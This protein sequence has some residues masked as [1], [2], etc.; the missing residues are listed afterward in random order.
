MTNPSLGFVH[1]HVPASTPSLPI[2]LLL[3]GTGGDENDLVPLGH[4]LLP[5][6]EIV[7]PRGKVLENGMPRFFRRL[8]EGVFDLEDLEFRAGELAEFVSSAAT[9]YGF[10]PQNLVA[11]G[12]SNGA[13]IA[14]A[15]LLL[16]PRTLAGA[17][18]FHAQIPLL[19][20]TKPDLQGKSIFLSGGRLDNLVPPGETERLGALLREY[21]ANLT[22]HWEQAGHNL[23]RG[24]IEAAH[25]WLSSI[26][27]DGSA[28][29]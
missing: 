9:A 26:W 8:A 13:N 2:L 25:D 16:H 4:M 22:L 10:D 27:T 19:P 21:G 15:T 7:A 3:H 6:A 18:L 17:V 24:E 29:H 12:Y 1:R 5:G 20:E 14:A 11:V 23:T 28:V